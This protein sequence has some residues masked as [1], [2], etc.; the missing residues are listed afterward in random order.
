MLLVKEWLSSIVIFAILATVATNILPNSNY[1]KYI[2]L[3][4]GL[5]FIVIII[6]P[7]TKYLNVNE[8]IGFN[9]ILEDFSVNY[10]LYSNSKVKD[11]NY[12]KKLVE[13]YEENVSANIKGYLSDQGYNIKNVE[14]KSDEEGQINSIDIEVVSEE[15]ILEAFNN[16]N[17]SENVGLKNI[18]KTLVC[19]FYNVDSDNINIKIKEI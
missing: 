18:I 17:E 2:K 3:F 19:Q 1:K 13:T 9:Y 4:I 7:I 11:D 10:S 16:S 8:D 15:S 12:T 14:V 5:M 6:S